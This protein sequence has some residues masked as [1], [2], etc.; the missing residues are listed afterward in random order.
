[1]HTSLALS[2]RR[3]I[4]FLKTHK[5]GSSTLASILYR[6]AARH[7]VTVFKPSGGHILNIAGMGPMRAEIVLHHISGGPFLRLD[8]ASFR[9]GY[10]HI[11]R[12]QRAHLVTIVREPVEHYL[13]CFHFFWKPDYG[14]DLKGDSSLSAVGDVSFFCLNLQF[15]IPRTMFSSTP[16]HHSLHKPPQTFSSA[17]R[18]TSQTR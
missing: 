16:V 11:L 9:A 12:G 10:F 8:W 14:L 17:E 13:S 2:L 6:Y 7:G 18:T 5:T 3:S 15:S 4:G 1:M